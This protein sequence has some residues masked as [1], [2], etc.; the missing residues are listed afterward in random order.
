MCFHEHSM[1][2]KHVGSFSLSIRRGRG[3]KHF[4]DHGKVLDADLMVISSLE[5]HCC[6]ALL[7]TQVGLL[8]P[9]LGWPQYSCKPPLVALGVK[10]G[11][12]SEQRS[13]AFE[14]NTNENIKGVA[15]G[16]F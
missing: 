13:L 16:K 2:G 15:S 1:Y 4:R 11:F 7:Q 3:T 10:R 14:G 9:Q 8:C 6:W 12:P 5:L